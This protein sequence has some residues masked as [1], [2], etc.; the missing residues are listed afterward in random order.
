[1]VIDYSPLA[2]NFTL[3]ST[4]D[5]HDRGE[6]TIT[7]STFDEPADVVVSSA[8]VGHTL[9]LTAVSDR[10]GLRVALPSTYEG[11][12]SLAS[13]GIPPN[14]K[15]DPNPADPSGLGRNRT[16]V[17]YMR[18]ESE[19]D[20]VDGYVHWG[21]HQRGKGLGVRAFNRGEPLTGVTLEI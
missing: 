12:L 10:G 21:R 13:P 16:V 19:S 17:H 20:Y 8:P 15:Y 14:F 7:T 18:S 2:V 1:M 11:P 9:E 3:A 6:F 5:D 4:N